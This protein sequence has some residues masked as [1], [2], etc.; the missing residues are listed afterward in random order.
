MSSITIT[1][2]VGPFTILGRDETVL[3]AGFT[4]VEIVR[5]R[6]EADFRRDLGMVRENGEAI[7]F[8][9]GG[10]REEARAL[11]RFDLIRMNW[12]QF[13]I[14]Q[15]RL[16][17]FNI[18][19]GS[20]IPRLL[21]IALSAPRVLAGL[22]TVGQMTVVG[23]TFRNVMSGIT[24][25]ATY[26]AQIAALRAGVARVRYFQDEM[27]LPITSEI[28]VE[29]GAANVALDN[30][31]IDLPDGRRLLE[32]D[33]IT[34]DKGD[35]VLIRGRSG[36]GKSTMLRTIAGLWPHG[37]GTVRLPDRENVMFLPQRSYMPDG[38][39][40][41]LL[42][43]PRLPDK[44]D[45]GRYVDALARLSLGAYGDRLEEH[46]EWRHIL[47][48]GEQQR[49]AVVRALLRK[50]DFLFLDEATSALDVELE[51][52]L[53][54]AL[55]ESLPLSAIVS[56]AHRPTVARYHKTAIDVG[57]GRASPGVVSQSQS[58][59]EL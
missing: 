25:F 54:R 35:R 55:T 53:Y 19:A 38:T 12:R 41:E 5:Q 48:P 45:H 46:A 49:I 57:A 2:P 43:F 7:A 50:P 39:L 23:E 11:A 4:R 58:S 42:T 20:I 1:T 31:T 59:E 52:D 26:Y 34:I 22:M 33:G 28:A 30:V 32:I 47:S 44:A 6:L 10:A 40:A 8:E 13:T 51:A 24:F 21:P 17:V 18:L 3:A 36:S 16:L 29:T 9:R 15:I 27:E 14:A 37:S 56:V